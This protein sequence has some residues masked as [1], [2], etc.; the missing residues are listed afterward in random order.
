MQP[1]IAFLAYYPEKKRSD[2]NSFEG[3]Y[4]IGANV[5]MDVLRRKGIS[6]DICTPDTAQ[7]YK[8]VLIS[9]TSDYS[10][11]NNW[12]IHPETMDDLHK[13]ALDQIGFQD[14]ITDQMAYWDTGLNME[15]P[16]FKSAGKQPAWIS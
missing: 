11:G 9:L 2:N 6:C 14:L 15:T 8:I 4:N 10:Q 16:V 5:I 3:N 13:P 1:K 7:K 12:D